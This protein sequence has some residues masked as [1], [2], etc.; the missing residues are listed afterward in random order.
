[1][2]AASDGDAKARRE[3]RRVAHLIVIVVAV[4]FI[5][6]SAVQ[7]V[8]AV[9]GAGF[10]PLASTPAGS[11]EDQCAAGVRSLAVALDRAGAM[12]WSESP[13]GGE[14][15]DLDA[16]RARQAFQRRLVPEWNAAADVE[17]AC[18]TSSAGLDAWASLLR[19]RR[20][21]EQVVLRGLVELI[22]LER[23]VTAHLPANL[24]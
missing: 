5:G 17:R 9:F 1:M 14:P 13:V 3:G 24:R 20:G 6:A 19:L 21:K 22:P 15:L 2:N 23:D 7:I 8:P 11:A 4:A 16:E 12:A 18:A 10:R